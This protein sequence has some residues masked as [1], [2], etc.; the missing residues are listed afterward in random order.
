MKAP[1]P[2]FQTHSVRPPAASASPL[3][4]G[5]SRRK[6]GW[7]SFCLGIF[8]SLAGISQSIAQCGTP[9]SR[10]YD[11]LVTG[12]GYG[13]YTLN[14][15]KWNPDSGALMSVRI[16]AMV[17]LQYGFTLANA[18][19]LPSLYTVMVGRYDQISSP[20]MSPMYS[21]ITQQSMGAYSLNP[22]ASVTKPPFVL[23]SSYAN[24]DTIT[25]SVASFIG[26]GSL[27][28]VYSP[29]TFT[30]VHTNNNASYSFAASASDSIHFS[31]SYQFCTVGLLASSLIRFTA[32]PQEPSTVQLSWTM[33]NEEAGR[34]YEVQQSV[35]GLDFT[36]AGSLPAV[37]G[38]T[39]N[40]DYVYD[41]SLPGGAIGSGPGAG[42]G[43]GQAGAGYA[44]TGTPRKWYFRLK[45]DAADGRMSYSDIKL[46][47]F[48]TDAGSGLSV[49]PNP[50]ADHVNIDF[51]GV[52]GGANGAGGGN[53]GG[54]GTSSVGV[55]GTGTAADWQVELFSADGRLLQRELYSNIHIARLNFRQALTPGTYFLRAT[56]RRTSREYSSSLL[57][58]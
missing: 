19:L 3:A 29:I 32:L 30:D 16:S 55:R 57:I 13:N 8:F 23:L 15:P 18:D 34:V 17:S 25:G 28:F 35:D 58:R 54:N 5:A 11:T 47:D 40:A 56:D 53:A 49:Y 7:L 21:N 2:S 48:G 33:A 39:G 1:S 37:P 44:A 31:V 4:P 26:P 45:I 20:A 24:V 12:P 41:W 43:A 10:T 51:D 46:V 9:G 22:G 52:T 38:G 6:K 42:V 50:A 36:T 14:F 27:S